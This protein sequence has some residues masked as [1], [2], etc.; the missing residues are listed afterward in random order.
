MRATRWSSGS[1]I[2]SRVR[3]A[4]TPR[5]RLVFHYSA[6]AEAMLA[7]PNLRV[8]TIAPCALHAEVRDPLGP[9]AGGSG[10]CALPGFY[11]ASKL[12]SLREEIEETRHERD[13]ILADAQ[14]PEDEVIQR[15][16]G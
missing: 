16:L 6:A 9:A 15:P 1:S 10:S 4:T 7:D 8:A 11:G 12:S 14:K 5:G 3:R 2:D 13:L